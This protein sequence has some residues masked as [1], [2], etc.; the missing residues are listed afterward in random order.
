MNELQMTVK[1]F[2][3]KYDKKEANVR[4]KI[5]R[6]KETLSGHITKTL[7]S[8]AFLLDEFAVD[9]LLSD[10]RET[11][12]VYEKAK[13]ETYEQKASA[14]EPV[15]NKPDMYL[16][17][18]SEKKEKVMKICFDEVRDSHNKLQYI[19]DDFKTYEL[20][21]FAVESQGLALQYVPNCF[22]TAELCSIAVNENSIALAY[23]PDE[24]KTKE[25]VKTAFDNYKDSRK[26][27]R[28]HMSMD[29]MD[30]DCNLLKYVP[31]ELLDEDICFKAIANC[32]CNAKYIPQRFFDDKIIAEAAK[33]SISRY[34][35]PKE[36]WTKPIIIETIKSYRDKTDTGFQGIPRELFD[37]RFYM[38][39]IEQ[40]L[41]KP[42]DVYGDDYYSGLLSPKEVESIRQIDTNNWRLNE[43]LH[44]L[45]RN[46]PDNIRLVPADNEQYDIYAMIAVCTKGD[47]LKYI[48]AEKRNYR[49]YEAAVTS[50]PNTLIYVPD[51]FKDQIIENVKKRND[52]LRF[53]FYDGYLSDMF[54]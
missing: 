53:I 52:R 39:L 50:D 19:P 6:S 34:Y 38:E 15:V 49:M 47:T 41:I 12:D 10:R 14:S 9:F 29:E 16:H 1:E 31:S 28:S 24:F 2:C 43:K 46:D 35:I 11:N 17:W 37:F 33:C 42:S 45:V 4:A 30:K 7:C 27:V 25:I 40:K 44:S 20:C 5:S 51:K 32:S 22:M 8:K 26:K 18:S 48:P 36:Y 13:E 3:E 21:K 23:V 54:I